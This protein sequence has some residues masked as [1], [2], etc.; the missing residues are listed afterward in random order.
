MVTLCLGL[1]RARQPAALLPLP[2]MADSSLR[3]C[4]RS[5]CSLFASQHRCSLNPR[6]LIPVHVFA[7]AWAAPSWA[8]AID[9]PASR[10]RQFLSLIAHWRGLLPHRKPASLFPCPEIADSS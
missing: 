2:E 10:A 9:V 6:W 1:L 8:S 3:S 7:L 5:G 4:P